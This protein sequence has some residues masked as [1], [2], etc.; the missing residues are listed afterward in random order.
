MQYYGT[1]DSKL[2]EYWFEN[3]LLKELKPGSVII[4][5]NAAFH[6]KSVI[7]LLAMKKDCSVLFLPPYSPDLN[8]IEKKRAWLK[9]WLRK[10]LPIFDSFDSALSTC[11]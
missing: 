7:P 5:D 6:E 9:K 3:G 10:I 2:F 11:F 1:T 4:L 8:P